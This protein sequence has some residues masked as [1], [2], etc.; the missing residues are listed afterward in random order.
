MSTIE[1]SGRIGEVLFGK[2]RREVLSL[3]FGDPD[4]AYHFSEIA[5]RVDS[6]RGAVQRELAGLV[7][8]GIA[9]RTRRGNQVL[10]QANRK[11][12]VFP[13]L[14]ALVLKTVGLSDVLRDALKP[15]ADRIAA[16]SVFGSFA[17]GEQRADSDVD[18]LVVGEV[19]FADVVA[20]LSDA[21]ERLGREI[22]PTVYPPDEFAH[23]VARGDHFLTAVLRGP[24]I[25]LLG[26]ED[27]L[28]RLAAR[29]S[30]D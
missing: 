4:L 19:G 30:S 11:C 10:Y 7:D 3:L 16:A 28:G 6:G 26:G 29:G 13:E 23:R 8:A 17:R 12:P 1:G 24:M 27:E 9:V 18:L 2:V 25:P 21:Q 14:S 15:L 22:N 20:A 5:R